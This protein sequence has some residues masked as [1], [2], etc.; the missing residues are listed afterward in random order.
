MYREISSLTHPVVKHLISLRDDAAYRNICNSV[1][2]QGKKVVNELVHSNQ[3]RLVVASD[4]ALVPSQLQAD[5][6]IIANDA[7][8][9][10]ISG[11]MVPEGIVAE[12]ARPPWSSL[13]GLTKVVALDGVS[14]PGNMGTLIRSAWALG[15]QG[16]FI[17]EGSCDPYNNKALRSAM[18][19]TFHLP[20]A[21]G[22]WTELQ[23]LVVE[24]RWT[25]LAADLE[26]APVDQ[27]APSPGIL[28]VLGAESHGI[29]PIA[30]NFCRAVTVPMIAEA[31]SLNVAVAG[32]ILMYVLGQNEHG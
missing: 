31:E 21:K 32:G 13:E 26:G 10:K 20:L 29:S 16:M 7:V 3:A 28:L 12:V 4:A 9:A 24:R 2:V 18:G 27:I 11:V 1:M 30:R 17:V 23:H 5:E 22:S 15:W 6:V 19:A 8:L 14:D 25:A